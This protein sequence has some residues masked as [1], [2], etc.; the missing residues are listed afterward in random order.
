M[1]KNMI[2]IPTA[3][4]AGIVGMILRF[5]E[6]NTIFDAS[7]GLA[8]R[9]APISIALVILSVL[10]AA[11]A[12]C[13][14]CGFKKQDV[15][16]DCKNA[17]PMTNRLAFSAVIVIGVIIVL[18]SVASA[19]VD[20]L[21]LRADLAYA[22]Y[23]VERNKILIEI[24]LKAVFLLLGVGAGASII[25]LTTCKEKNGKTGALAVIPVL[26][27]C[28]W[29]VLTYKDNNTNP[30][31]VEYCYKCFAVAAATVSFYYAAGYEYGKVTPRRTIVF[32]YLGA[33]FCLVTVL[34]ADDIAQ[35]VM[36]A[37]LAVMQLIKCG[38][39][40]KGMQN[41]PPEV[42]QEIVVKE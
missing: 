10:F 12:L 30:V 42:N 37:V 28:F 31:L 23:S 13:S 7:N 29:L 11:F 32:H 27:L 25:K 14:V 33:Y 36:F 6:V 26:F 18:G 41:Q 4:A 16:I 2:V 39:F 1:R 5:V 15:K 17:F 3:L 35:S 22:S 8:E 34:D 40:I 21:A 19:G 38:A 9:Y 24:I 20:I